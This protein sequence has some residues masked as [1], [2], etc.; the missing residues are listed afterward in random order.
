MLALVGASR[1]AIPIIDWA[2]SFPLPEGI[3]TN[4]LIAVLD[5]VGMAAGIA[6]LWVIDKV[7]DAAANKLAER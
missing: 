4:L 6:V 2:S 3:L 5:T 1:I 7:I